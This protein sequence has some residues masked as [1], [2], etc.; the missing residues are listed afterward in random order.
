VSWPDPVPELQVSETL[1]EPKR[2]LP[3]IRGQISAEVIYQQSL[4]LGQGESVKLID[5]TYTYEVD[6]FQLPRDA[7]TAIDAATGRRYC[8][9]LPPH[10][11]TRFYYD[12]TNRKLRF[13]G[14]F[15]PAVAGESFLLLNVISA[16]DLA[17]LTDPKISKD[18]T[19]LSKVSQLAALTAQARAVRRPWTTGSGRCRSSATRGRSGRPTCRR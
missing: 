17:S 14:L 7:N 16:R 3:A 2:G 13:K 8:T 11:A 15:V 1:T 12:P 18:G 19:F 10:L 6:L 9:E 5:P 4:A